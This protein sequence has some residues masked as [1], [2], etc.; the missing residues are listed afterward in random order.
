MEIPNR[1]DIDTSVV[2]HVTPAI[3]QKG[4]DD[5][6]DVNNTQQTVDGEG[7]PHITTIYG[8]ESDGSPH[9]KTISDSESH[10]VDNKAFDLNDEGQ[11]G[12]SIKP[13]G[14]YF[15]LSMF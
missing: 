12:S 14:N 13:K 11:L 2:S 9:I 15:N 5:C 7:S 3:E 4:F 8:S 1:L 10:G 6:E